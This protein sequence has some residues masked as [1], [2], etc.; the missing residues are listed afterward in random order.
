[1][2]F[3]LL[4]LLEPLQ[5]QLWPLLRLVQAEFQQLELLQLLVFDQFVLDF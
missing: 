4:A 2:L 1:M 5:L 3:E